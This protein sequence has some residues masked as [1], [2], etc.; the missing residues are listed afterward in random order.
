MMMSPQPSGPTIADYFSA[1]TYAG[2][3]AGRNLVTG[4]DADLHWIKRMD[5][6]ANH[7]L[8]DKLRG[9]TKALA[10]NNISAETTLAQG[11]TAFLTDGATLGTDATVNASGG[12]YIDWAF[13]NA[14]G[15]F[16]AVAY[17]GN[18]ASGRAIAHSLGVAPGLVIIRER[19]G[20]PW[21]TYAPAATNK[22]GVLSS[23]V[24]FTAS[25]T[26]AVTAVSSSTFTVNG[27]SEI[28]QNGQQ[29]IAYLFAHDTGPDGMVRC[30]IY[31]GTSG[32]QYID[33]GWQP[34]FVMIKG[35]SLTAHWYISDA[36]RGFFPTASYGALQANS[37]VA[38]PT[39][40]AARTDG[41]PT[42]F[43]VTTNVVNT[44]GAEYFY[45]AIRKP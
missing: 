8:Y 35:T 11:V 34:Q 10:T 43:G 5:V 19:G 1:T 15:F 17:T 4:I 25:A 24:A 3:G 42:S 14:P 26:S 40:G 6:T 18:G 7:G 20:G 9:T 44:S 12:T 36:A 23:N 32:T 16:E 22:C 31:T 28:N 39:S 13:K 27:G 2:T 38:H 45:L 29:Y 37:D 30:G 21:L 41:T 33:I